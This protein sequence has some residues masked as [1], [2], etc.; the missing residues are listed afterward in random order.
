MKFEWKAYEDKLKKLREFL[1]EAQALSP[2]MEARLFLPGEEG[3]DPS[4]QV[5]YVLLCYYVN[6]DRCYQR[7]VELFEYYL[8]GDI[9]E[10]I[11]KLT[12]IAEEFAM[13]IEQSEFGGG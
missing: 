6:E 1:S 8:Q 2:D 12:A 5:P 4:V 9:K 11:N 10:L 13:E 3:A 7:K